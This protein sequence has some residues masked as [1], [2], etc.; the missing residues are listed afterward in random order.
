M[1]SRRRLS[2]LLR[3]SW[4]LWLP[5]VQPARIGTRDD[6]ASILQQQSC[7]SRATRHQELADA[8]WNAQEA[9]SPYE[10]SSP[11]AAP[12]CQAER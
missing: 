2:L 6:R 5:S 10:P 4:F 3:P 7:S 1:L 11:F 9:A 12:A 8:E